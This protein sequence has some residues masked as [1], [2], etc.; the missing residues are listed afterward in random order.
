MKIHLWGL[1]TRSLPVSLLDDWEPQPFTPGTENGPGPGDRR[2]SYGR[3]VA[4]EKPGEPEPG[5][6]HQ[7]IAASIMR[8]EIFP[9]W[10][11]TGVLRRTPVAVGDT[12]G[13]LFHA[14][15][16]TQLFFAAR[17]IEVFDGLASGGEVWRTGFTYRTLLGHPEL[18]EETF[19][20][21]K[22]LATGAVTASLRSWSRPGTLLARAFAPVVRMLQVRASYAALDHLASIAS[23]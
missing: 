1:D 14:P 17:A 9:P 23:G 8:Y 3:E 6:A 13:I 7:R 15:A 19:A 21:E 20:V 10:M 11:I 4:Q 22:N 16:G 12:V 2:D 18:G 5:G